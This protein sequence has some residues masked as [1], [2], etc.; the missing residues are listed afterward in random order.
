MR[1]HLLAQLSLLATLCLLAAIEASASLHDY[2][3]GNASMR[4]LR[5]QDFEPRQ[6]QQ[7]SERESRGFHFTPSGDDV[8]VE[9]E[10]IVPF[11]RV[12]V[13]R[14]MRLARDALRSLMNLQTEALVNTAVIVAAGAIIAGIVRLVLAPIVFSSMANAYG[15]GYY[16]SQRL[17]EGDNNNSSSNSRSMRSL[18]QT[19]ASQLDAQRLDVSSCA[20][21]SICQYLQNNRR[22]SPAKLI[23]LIANSRWLDTYLNGTAVFNAIDKARGSHTCAQIY[24]SCSWQVLAGAASEEEQQQPKSEHGGVRLISF[25][26]VDRDIALGLNYLLPFVEVPTKRKRS[27]APKPLLIVN[28]AAIVSGGLVVAGGVLVGHLLRSM[29]LETIVPDNTPDHRKRRLD[30]DEQSLLQLFEHFKLV[31]RNDSGARVETSLPSLVDT[32]ERTFLENDI[33]LP[34]CLLKA[35][36][37]VTQQASESARSGAATDLQL[38]LD[39][40][41]NW[42]WLLS[43]LEQTALHEAIAAGRVPGVNQCG[44]KYPRCK[45]VAPEQQLLQLLNN[46]VQFT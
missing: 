2:Y 34:V 43:W 7:H 35:I 20:Q 38:L 14:S 33:N 19:L 11:V 39:S 24:R 44:V 46:N 9:M 17:D 45:W 40:L 26:A 16:K 6:E 29:G 3:Y 32:I 27:G 4:T 28:S 36:C 18:T 30:T 1:Q 21:R 12:P 41:T 23:Q 15:Q 10:F 37:S 22:G 8:S 5:F 13:K 42:S 25:D 31:Y